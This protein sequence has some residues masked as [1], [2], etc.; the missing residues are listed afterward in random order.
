MKTKGLLPVCGL[1][2]GVLIGMTVGTAIPKP[3]AP[4]VQTA[5]PSVS[6]VY[7]KEIPSAV[8]DETLLAAAVIPAESVPAVLPQIRTESAQVEEIVTAMSS[9]PEESDDRTVYITPSG[10]K[11][12]YSAKCAGQNAAEISLSEAKKI[13]DPCKKCVK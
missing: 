11:Y 6:I 4:A 12:H 8:T 3:Q 7:I 1:V 5:E 9:S 13:K 2:G 10:K